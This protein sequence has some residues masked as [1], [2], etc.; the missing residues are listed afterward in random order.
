MHK[1]LIILDWDDTLF[2]TSWVLKNNIDVN[3]TTILNDNGHLFEKLDLILY[4]L[5][6]NCLKC[7]KV[8]IVTNAM[9]KWVTISSK[10][11]PKTKKLIDKNIDIISARDIYQK[12]MPKKQFVWKKLIFEQLVI[13]H[14]MDKQYKVENIIS[15][16]DADYEFQALIDLYED[17]KMKKRILKAIKFLQGPDYE[18]LIDQ[19]QV[20]N[21][22]IFKVCNSKNHMD[23]KFKDLN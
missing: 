23:L 19:L 14:F 22:S 13:E 20:L 3:D 16:G 10:M 2:P 11:L 21:K 17:F 5:L 6:L 15:I 1:T 7:G 18:S 12:E 8:V 4:K 9:V